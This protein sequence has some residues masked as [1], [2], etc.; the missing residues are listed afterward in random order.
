MGKFTRRDFLKA[1]AGTC[2]AFGAS[3]ILGGAPKWVRTQ[4]PEYIEKELEVDPK[5]D[6]IWSSKIYTFFY[7]LI[8][9]CQ[10]FLV[11]LRYPAI[12]K[13][14]DSTVEVLVRVNKYHQAEIIPPLPLD[15]EPYEVNQYL[16]QLK[17]SVVIQIPL[18]LELHQLMKICL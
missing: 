3:R 18:T 14:I 6:P 9:K 7:N 16:L 12:D 13:W 17:I 4:K 10:W 8:L 2:A 1:S 5:S 15:I 11:N